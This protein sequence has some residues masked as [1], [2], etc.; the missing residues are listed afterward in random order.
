MTSTKASTKSTQEQKYVYTQQ[1][2][3]KKRILII[4]LF[5]LL[6]ARLRF[7]ETQRTQRIFGFH[8]KLDIF[9]CSR[10]HESEVCFLTSMKGFNFS[11]RKIK[12]MK[13]RP[14]NN[15]ILRRKA[16]QSTT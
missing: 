3:F 15:V 5:H 6:F 10:A 8:V 2:H 16:T 7:P 4:T 12:L 13:E 9:Q 14:V 1:F 11:Q